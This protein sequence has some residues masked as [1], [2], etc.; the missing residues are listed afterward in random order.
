MIGTMYWIGVLM[1]IL[2]VF[3][4]WL[5]KKAIKH[6]IDGGDKCVLAIFS[7]LFVGLAI[8]MICA[9]CTMHNKVTVTIT[10]E[11][12]TVSVYNTERYLVDDNAHYYRIYDKDDDNWIE[13]HNIKYATLEYLEK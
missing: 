4:V 11:D 10:S 3:I 8:P 12:G 9:L 13:Y 6:E 7:I 5:T 2:A 1:A